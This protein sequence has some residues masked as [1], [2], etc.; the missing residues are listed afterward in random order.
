MWRHALCGHRIW[1]MTSSDVDKFREFTKGMVGSPV[2]HLW[3]G[4]GSALFL[5]FGHLTPRIRRDGS[6]GNPKG[7]WTLSV[8]WS[9][10]IDGKRRIWCGSW[11]DHQRW[12]H[13]LPNLKGSTVR[14]IDLFG[15]LGEVDLHLSNGLNLLS[16]MTEQGDPAWSITNPEGVAIEVVA[17]RLYFDERDRNRKK[18]ESA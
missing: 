9:W 11:S 1:S 15:K 14:S 16:F 7:E 6:L 18:G 13:V 12:N 8:E 10:R 3:N 2:G 5:E 4:Y 17:G